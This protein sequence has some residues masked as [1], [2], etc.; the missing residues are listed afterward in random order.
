MNSIVSARHKVLKH[1][2]SKEGH[3]IPSI[4]NRQD[5]IHPQKV[6]LFILLTQVDNFVN[7]SVCSYRNLKPILTCTAMV[8][9]PKNLALLFP[10]STFQRL[11]WQED[12]K[13]LAWAH[14]GLLLLHQ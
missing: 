11:P 10:L 1:S 7:L 13:T 5:K 3:S 8:L 4:D 9:L 12:E 2:L 6:E 14:H